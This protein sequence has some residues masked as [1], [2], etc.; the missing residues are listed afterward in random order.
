MDKK[1]II[2]VVSF[3]FVG[4]VILNVINKQVVPSEGAEVTITSLEEERDHLVLKNDELSQRISELKS[5][6]QEEA[7]DLE[8]TELSSDS[9]EEG[10]P[11]QMKD[12]VLT[13]VTQYINFESI[14]LRN[15][16]VKPFLTNELIKKNSID[17]ITNADFSS[18]G[19]V[20]EVIRDQ[21]DPNIFIVLGKDVTRD[22]NHQFFSKIVIDGDKISDYSFDY[23]AVN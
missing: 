9:H 18:S 6:Q 10:V 21:Y 5:N 8:K 4:I 1:I 12:M 13:F 20:T 19:E 11:D 7:I 17:V 16:S 14:D 23:V 3:L 2:F 15:E 22:K